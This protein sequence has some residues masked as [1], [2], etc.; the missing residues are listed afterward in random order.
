MFGYD[1]VARPRR[2]GS[3]GGGWLPVGGAAQ[4][5]AD[6]DGTALQH[7]TPAIAAN[8]FV[9]VAAVR[10][11]LISSFNNTNLAQL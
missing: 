11:Y 9:A 8:G 3:A 5:Q 2:V 10:A 1:S 6:F 4:V 7:L